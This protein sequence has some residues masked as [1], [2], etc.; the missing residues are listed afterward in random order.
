MS[1]YK[2]T[3]KVNA[4]RFLHIFINL[5]YKVYF[6]TTTYNNNM[7]ITISL[8]QAKLLEFRK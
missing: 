8:T 5:H 2:D 3:T 4:V 6:S 1:I 7:F